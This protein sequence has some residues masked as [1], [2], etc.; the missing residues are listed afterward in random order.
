MLHCLNSDLGHDAISQGDTLINPFQF[1]VT[2]V[3]LIWKMS[4]EARKKFWKGIYSG[5]ESLLGLSD[6][7]F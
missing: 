3:W 6:S 1:Y 7:A 2:A 5:R 4:P